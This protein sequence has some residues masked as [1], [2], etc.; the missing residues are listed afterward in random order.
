MSGKNI[1]VIMAG[2]LGKRMNSDLPKVLHKINGEPMLT[3][4]IKET[5]HI[6]PEKIFIIVGKYR[7]IIESTIGEYINKDYMKKYITFVDQPEP[8]GTGHAIKCCCLSPD[9]VKY[10]DSNVL[11]LSGDV[12]LITF[13]TMKEML[14]N[15]DR[16]RIM[17]TTLE[18]PHGYGRIVQDHSGDF[19]KIVEEKD[20]SDKEKSIQ[21]INCGIYAFHAYILHKYIVYIE[22]NNSQK[23]YYLTDIFQIINEKFE[24]KNV[25]EIHEIPIIR[26]KEI[27]GVNT[28]E[29]LEQLVN[30]V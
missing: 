22:N 14:N 23:E 4:I 18:I 7:A 13:Q 6:N 1:V 9:F 24:E 12:P 16:V 11:I 3:K 26:Q 10:I 15:V 2:G 19:V 5:S 20:C 29:Q 17:T 21:K 25:I 27:M 30:F 28:P 8:L